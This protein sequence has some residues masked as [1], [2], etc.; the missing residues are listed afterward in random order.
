MN[1]SYTKVRE[2][3]RCSIMQ[4]IDFSREVPDSEVLDLI[5]RQLTNGGEDPIEIG[6]A[7]V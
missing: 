7:H 1:P 2:E 3:I 6:R 4:Q 5:D